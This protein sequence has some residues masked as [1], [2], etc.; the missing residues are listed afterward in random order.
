M[1]V[2]M[3]MDAR[4]PACKTHTSARA[5]A[6]LLPDTREPD[7]ALIHAPARTRMSA[8]ARAQT[9][10]TC[11]HAHA[12]AQRTCLH[13]HAFMRT[14]NAHACRHTH[15]RANTHAHAH[16]HVRTHTH[17]FSL[18]AGRLGPYSSAVM[19]F[20]KTVSRLGCLA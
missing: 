18:R 5:Q 9:T 14:H 8:H 12:H 3:R 4:A 20:R 7:H 16:A 15:T 17:I 19:L 1:H 13:V 2:H 11:M 10:C 6:R